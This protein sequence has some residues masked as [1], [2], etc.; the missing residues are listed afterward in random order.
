MPGRFYSNF[1]QF[2]RLF[3]GESDIPLDCVC[4]LPIG[5]VLIFQPK[6]VKGFIIKSDIMSQPV[7]VPGPQPKS[8]ALKPGL[9]SIS[10]KTASLGLNMSQIFRIINIPLNINAG[11]DVFTAKG[12]LKNNFTF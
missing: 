11:I 4:L 8:R 2:S 9:I 3:L 1:D 12:S 6:A 10:L 7:P 5:T